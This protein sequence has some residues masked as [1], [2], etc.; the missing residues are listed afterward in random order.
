MENLRGNGKHHQSSSNDR[1]FSLLSSSFSQ[2]FVSHPHAFVLYKSFSLHYLL[3]AYI[4][5]VGMVTAV[6]IEANSKLSVKKRKYSDSSRQLLFGTG[7]P[8]L[9]TQLTVYMLP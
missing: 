8:R 6:K 4:V 5:G 1:C 7:A 3:A 2:S 9:T